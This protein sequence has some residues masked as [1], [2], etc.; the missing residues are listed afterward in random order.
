MKLK[1]IS[2]AN[3]EKGTLELPEQ[4]EEP[5][6]PDLIKRAVEALQANARQKYGSDPEAGKKCSA[7]LSRRRRKYRGSYGH[8]ISRVPRKILSRRGTRFNWVGAFAPGT[9]GGRRAHPPK[10]EKNWTKKINILERRKA[11]RSAISATVNTESVSE[12][13]HAVPDKY[14]F[15]FDNGFENVSKTKE[16]INILLAAGFTD[17][18]K[19]AEKK[20]FRAGV[21]R[22][23][24]RKYRKRKGP[25]LVVSKECDLLKSGVNIP[26]VDVAIVNTLNAELLAPGTV[27]GRLTIFT[28]AAIEKLKQDNLFTGKPCKYKPKK[29]KSGKDKS[30]K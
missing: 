1:I 24:G 7:E 30:K 11:I 27:P 25:L 5:I 8:G 21:A 9:V 26:G 18:L 19:R 3:E 12:R 13:G 23:R 4:F 10:A 2:T 14:P 28:S 6:R 16:V 20:T 22:L 17:E 15:V 29:S